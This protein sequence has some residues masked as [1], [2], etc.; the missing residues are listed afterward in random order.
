VATPGRLN[1]FIEQNVIDFRLTK[2]F[3]LDEADAMLDFGFINDV[4]KIRN[5]ILSDSK[6]RN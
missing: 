1:D 6:R 5:K 3:V 2:I 4:K